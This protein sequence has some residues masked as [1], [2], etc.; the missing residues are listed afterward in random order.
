MTP[1]QQ[2]IWRER[3]DTVP[4]GPGLG[5]PRGNDGTDAERV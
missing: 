5:Q 2:K 1:E 4:L 3:S